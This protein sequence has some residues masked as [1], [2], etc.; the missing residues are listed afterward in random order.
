MEMLIEKTKDTYYEAL[1]A[2]SL[3]WHDN[4]NDYQPFVLYYLG[5]ILKA[6]TE[7]ESRISYLTTQGLSKP[8][9]I[10]TLIDG[11]LGKFTKKDLMTCCPDISKTTIER[12]LAQLRKDGYIEKI[13]VGRNTAYIRK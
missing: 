1:Q 11:Y 7:F 9:R 8:E 10:K 12:T 3:G 2:S 6:Y 5:I 4:K 13:G